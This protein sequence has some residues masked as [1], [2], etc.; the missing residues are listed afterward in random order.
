MTHSRF[1]LPVSAAPAAFSPA[2]LQRLLPDLS[3][4]PAQACCWVGFSG[5]LDSTVLL[6]ALAQLH[7]PIRLR[8]LHINHQISPYADA[9]Q[10]QC[11]AFCAQLGIAFSAEKVRVINTGK[12]VEDAARTARYEVFERYLGAG[13]LLLT[14]HHANDQAETLLLRLVRGTG[15][16]GLAAMAAQRPLGNGLLVRPLL[17]FSR[18]QLEA[19]ARAQQL[20]WVEDESNQDDAYDRN[21][22]RNQVLPLLVQRW[23]ALMRKWQQTAELCAEQEDLLTELAQADLRAATP[24]AERVGQS[25]DLQALKALS[26]ARVQ[27]LLRYWLRSQG[28]S[29]PEQNH[30]QQIRQQLLDA[31]PDSEANVSWGDVSLRLFR[32]RLYRLPVRL[33]TLALQLELCP[34]ADKPMLSPR[35]SNLQIRPRLGGE[36]CKPAGR[37]H[38]QTLKKLLQEYGLEPWW[39]EQLPLV[40]SGDELVAVGDLWVCEGYAAEPGEAG[41]RLGWQLADH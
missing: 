31:K 7:L 22:L 16:R 18:A 28:L 41:Y 33:P 11:A 27:N 19:Y 2:A 40:Y 26:P 20:R 13:D 1:P 3:Q 12:G 29:A 6:H 32:G 23:P 21:F 24:R 4:L 30:W 25:I 5:G 39:R 34:A 15:P 10:Q 35:L 36:R 9:W 38:S 14:A 37:A 17:G 8:A